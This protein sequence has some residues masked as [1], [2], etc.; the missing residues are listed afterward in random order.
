MARD[1]LILEGIIKM[2]KII[3]LLSILSLNLLSVYAFEIGSISVDLKDDNLV[4]SSHKGEILDYEFDESLLSYAYIIETPYFKMS[5]Y[6]GVVEEKYSKGLKI[7]PK[8]NLN[9]DDFISFTF[10]SEQNN[11]I[12][13]LTGFAG[14]SG[15]S[16]QQVYFI[17]TQTGNFIKIGLT[18][19]QEMDWITESKN[20]V[21]YK[22]FNTSTYFFSHAAS[23][24]RKAR[25]SGVF[26]FDGDGKAVSDKEALKSI[27]KTEYEKI[28]FSDEK[29][30][31]LQKNIMPGYRTLGEKLIDFV[32]YGFK[33]GKQEEVFTF[34][35]TLHPIY[36]EEARYYTELSL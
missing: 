35:N 32:Y 3:L 17:N 24:G 25:I 13:L 2:K 12:G 16:S 6:D 26:Y 14:A 29:K 22:N 8:N 36:E 10:L 20:I 5:G 34:L 11:T 33:L 1:F 15:G 21:G 28:V 31:L 30:R 9:R 27:L 23:W 7:L 4:I 19:M 18:D